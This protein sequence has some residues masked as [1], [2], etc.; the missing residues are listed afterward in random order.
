VSDVTHEQVED[1]ILAA[2]RPLVAPTGYLKLLRAYNGE[3][4]DEE[5]LREHADAILGQSPAVF[6]G[7]AG[8]D[9][10]PATTTGQKYRERAHFSVLLVSCSYRGRDAARRGS[11]VAGEAPGLFRMYRDV[12]AALAEKRLGLDIGRFQP[13]RSEVL[14][15]YERIAVARL[16]VSCVLTFG[17]TRAV[18]GAPPLG[19]VRSGLVLPDETTPRVEGDATT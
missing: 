8:S 4:D 19:T 11:G 6:V 1:A 14:L 12:R 10:E 17:T 2:L 18:A 13:K 16:D 9:M 5:H 7:W 15:Q 3:F